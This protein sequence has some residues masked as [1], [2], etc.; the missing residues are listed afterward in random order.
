M[1]TAGIKRAE[2][3]AL[4]G[5]VGHRRLPRHC[6]GMSRKPIIPAS[7]TK[8]PFSLEDAR[9]AGL[10]LSSLRGKA[11][12][13][14][15]AELYCWQGLRKDPWLELSA[16]N[17]LLPPEAVFSGATA[18]WMVGLDLPPTDPVEVIVPL[19]SSIRSRAGVNVRRS[20][21]SRSDL[22]TIPALAEG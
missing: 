1:R 21:L 13:R 18:A 14:L 11:W 12:R 10:T 3:P 15:G 16:L 4:T 2:W 20:R 17:R 19:S 9:R 5:W 6:G 7:L 8:R 22:A